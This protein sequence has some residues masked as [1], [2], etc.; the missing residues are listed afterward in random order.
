MIYYLFQGNPHLNKE[1]TIYQ[2]QENLTTPEAQEVI[3]TV[4]EQL[5][6][7]GIQQGIQQGEIQV[8]NKLLQLKFGQEAESHHARL[9]QLSPIELETLVEKVMKASS[10]EEVFADF[11]PQSS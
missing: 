4:A 2:V 5:R 7:E 6:Q 10:L 3:M 9:A 8:V 1:E 11:P